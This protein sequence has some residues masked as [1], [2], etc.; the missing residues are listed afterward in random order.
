MDYIEKRVNYSTTYLTV[1]LMAAAVI[2][3]I[4]YPPVSQFL[5]RSSGSYVMYMLVVAILLGLTVYVS[6]RVNA[7]WGN[8]LQSMQ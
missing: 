2:I 7:E 8:G 3:I 1:A 5:M 4:L 6:E